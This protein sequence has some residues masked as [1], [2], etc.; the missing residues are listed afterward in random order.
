MNHCFCNTPTTSTYGICRQMKFK[1]KQGMR[2]PLKNDIHSISRY[3][4]VIFIN[5]LPLGEKLTTRRSLEYNTRSPSWF[6]ENVSGTRRR[7]HF[8][9]PNCHRRFINKLPLQSWTGDGEP[10]LNW[11]FFCEYKANWF[12]EILHQKSFRFW[13]R[14]KVSSSLQK[15]YELLLNCYLS[16]MHI[17]HLLHPV[18]TESFWFWSMEREGSKWLPFVP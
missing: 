3:M 2:Q 9:I 11:T 17:S 18:R 5:W 12:N 15:M 14:K 16:G 7:S 10:D 1:Y 6:E 13:I 4:G 8:V